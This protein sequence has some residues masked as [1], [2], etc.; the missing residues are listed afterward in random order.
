MSKAKRSIARRLDAAQLAIGGALANADIQGY[1]AEYGYDLTRL[2]AG[3][4]LYQA[5][6]AAHHRQKLQ[7][8]NQHAATVEVNRLW[9]AAHADYTRYVKV[10][11]VALQDDHS[12]ATQLALRGRRKRPLSSWLLQAQQFYENALTDQAILAQLAGFGITRDK[13][14]AGL[15]QVEAVEAANLLQENARGEAQDATQV[16]DAALKALEAWLN[17]FMAIARVALEPRPQLLEALG[18]VVPS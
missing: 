6:L 11:R 18:I 14:E 1:L 12:A 17:D 2:Q 7:Y 10:A 4:A 16:R 13:L 3:Q 8:G 9:R 15:A 5:A